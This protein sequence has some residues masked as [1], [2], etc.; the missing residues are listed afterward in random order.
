MKERDQRLSNIRAA[1]CMAVV[2]L[3]TFFACF[4]LGTAGTI[5]YKIT[6]LIRNLMFWAV[7]CFVM[8]TG[9]LLLDPV[10][11][12]TYRKVFRKYIPRMVAALVLFA[13]V[14]KG[15]DLAFGFSAWDSKTV[16]EFLKSLL[17]GQG[18]WN[19]MWYLYTMIA[20]YLLMPIFHGACRSVD[21]KTV[22][23]AVGVMVLFLSVKPLLESIFDM[24]FGFYIPVAT[25]YPLYLFLG[26]AMTAGEPDFCGKRG[27]VGFSVL[28]VVFLAG[29]GVST[30]VYLNKDMVQLK[31]IVNDY[32]FLATV[33]GAVG[34]FGLIRSIG[35]GGKKL[36]RILGFIDKHS[37]GIYL[38]H[39]IPL[40]IL[41]MKKLF[42]PYDIGLW[43]VF[44]VAAG[45]FLISLLVAFAL[46]KIPGLSK[47]L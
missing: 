14:M 24:S 18:L 3:H 5:Q 28:V 38:I 42:N 45:V 32:S 33:I 36:G 17:T 16:P 40:K 22:W 21:R 1:A 13:A 27:L 10:R 23:I 25:I 2:I 6:V 8:V 31:E 29:M 43:F 44:V 15:I 34:V 11:E 9:A 30:F 7:P 20:L 46:K 41:V 4:S 12:I 37:F 35:T 26:R 19:H 39:M 47:I